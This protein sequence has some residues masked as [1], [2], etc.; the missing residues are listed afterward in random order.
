MSQ[1]SIFRQTQIRVNIQVDTDRD[2]DLVMMLQLLVSFVMALWQIGQWVIR[3]ATQAAGL[4]ASLVDLLSF[5]GKVIAIT[6]SAYA[7]GL[8]LS[9]NKILVSR[10]LLADA[11]S[12]GA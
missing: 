2:E 12:V 6:F 1:R 8:G 4:L 7:Y 3:L 9:G 11:P 5:I 10:R